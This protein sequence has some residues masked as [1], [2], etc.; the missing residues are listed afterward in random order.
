MLSQRASL[1]WV[2]VV[3]KSWAGA[4]RLAGGVGYES[5][6]VENFKNKR[7]GMKK[8]V[9]ICS[10]SLVHNVPRTRSIVCLHFHSKPSSDMQI[11]DFSQGK[12]EF[13]VFKVGGV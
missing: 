13:V 2:S 11:C 4:A 6:V 5:G 1:G 12:S 7:V 9:A 10:S 8:Q 3:H